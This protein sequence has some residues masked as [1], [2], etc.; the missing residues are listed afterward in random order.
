MKK[1]V[2][3]IHQVYKIHQVLFLI[4]FLVLSIF[5]PLYAHAVAIS[6]SSAIP[7]TNATSSGP[8]A[9][10]ANFYQLALLAGGIIAFGAI[11]YGGVLY[12]VSAGNASKQTE[13]KEWITSALLGL[14]LLAG[15]WLILYTINPNLVNLSLPNLTPLQTAGGSSPQDSAASGYNGTVYCGGS[16]SG[17][18]PTAGQTCSCTATGVGQTSCSCQSPSSFTCGGTTYGTC[19]GN[20]TCTNGSNNNVPAYHCVGY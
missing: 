3:K 20:G 2:C 13:G 5:S 9:Y 16:T 14:L 12:A 8:G 17:V 18:C 19:S 7:G 11:V 4:G 1:I 6:V 15:A 10:I